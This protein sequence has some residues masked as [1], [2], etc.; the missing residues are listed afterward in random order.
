MILATGDGFFYNSEN[1]VITEF[2]KGNEIFTNENIFY[3][4]KEQALDFGLI[5]KE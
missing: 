1:I 3:G 4:T 2:Q 5:F